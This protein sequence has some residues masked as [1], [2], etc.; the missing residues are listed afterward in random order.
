MFYRFL[1]ENYVYKNAKFDSKFLHKLK[2]NI[3]MIKLNRISDYFYAIFWIAISRD[4]HHVSRI[5]MILYRS[6][7]NNRLIL[8]CFYNNAIWRRAF[9]NEFSRCFASRQSTTEIK[10]LNLARSCKRHLLSNHSI[11][12]ANIRHRFIFHTNSSTFVSCDRQF[13]YI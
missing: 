9:D 12:S 10:D 5:S 11:K 2:M 8:F 3:Y 13:R 7:D 4:L 1:D 6:L